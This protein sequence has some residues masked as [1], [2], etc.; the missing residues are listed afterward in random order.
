MENE[1]QKLQKRINEKALA[2]MNNTLKAVTRKEQNKHYKEAIKILE[3]EIVKQIPNCKFTLRK[4]QEALQKKLDDVAY[5]KI[6]A[7]FFKTIFPYIY[8]KKYS[9]ASTTIEEYKGLYPRFEK[10][11]DQWEKNILT[12]EKIE[13][14]LHGAIIKSKNKLVHIEI[15]N[16]SQGKMILKSFN[17]KRESLILLSNGNFKN[18]NIYNLTPGTLKRFLSENMDLN[19][20]HERYCFVLY[21][22]HKKSPYIIKEHLPELKAKKQAQ[23]DIIMYMIAYCNFLIQKRK[24]SQC[25]RFMKKLIN[26]YETNQ[27][28]IQEQRLISKNLWNYYGKLIKRKK[29]RNARKIL[30][31]LYKYFKDTPSGQKAKARLN[32]K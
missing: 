16:S 24:I 10:E 8:M 11:L 26:Q 3:K 22:L 30:K 1:I 31:I 6:F 13:K 32:I 20:F 14:N 23:R 2:A 12:I 27:V 28:F 18:A 5:S 15:E 17:K 9:D 29:K 19:S 4:K 7:Q 21:L 25:I